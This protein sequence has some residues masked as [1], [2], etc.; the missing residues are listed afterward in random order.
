MYSNPIKVKNAVY[1]KFGD[2]FVLRFDGTYYLYP[3][4]DNTTNEIFCYTS[5]DLV[6]FIYLCGECSKR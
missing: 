2:P 3:S 6:H 1:N 4:G 5:K